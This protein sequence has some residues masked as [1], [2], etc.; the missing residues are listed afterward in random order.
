MTMLDRDAAATSRTLRTQ[1]DVEERIRAI[2]FKT[3]PPGKVGAELEWTVHHTA[4]PAEPLRLSS[5]RQALG[6]HAPHTLFANSPELPLPADGLV[7]CEP[8]GQVELS[9]A[10]APSL[11]ALHEAVSSDHAHLVR[12]LDAAGLSLGEHGID[13]HRTPRRLLRTPRYDAMEHA[14]DGR[15]PHGRI[16]MCS[17]AGLQACLDA[18]PPGQVATR[19]AAANAVGPALLAAFATADRHAG[20]DTG[21]ASARMGAWL[22]MDP[23]LTGPVTGPADDPAEG[24]VRYALAA[25]V[26]CVRG[27]DTWIAPAGLTLTGWLDGAVGRPLTEAD[28]DY[29]LSTLFPPVRPRGYLEIRYLDAQPG[30]GWFAPVAVLATLLGRP[31]VTDR[32][33]DLAAATADRWHDASRL[34]LADRELRRTA[35]ALLDLACRNLELPAPLGASLLDG[36]RERL[37]AKEL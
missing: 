17:T 25:P 13:P 21:W 32:A 36:V 6:P 28:L 29:H 15:G 23:R 22:G 4:A 24:W 37:H 20:R 33:L 35:A 1:E 5:L 11:T 18:G 31:E 9:S 10:P 27:D 34:G 12:L 16:M 8:G 2:C 14:F 26:V 19:W 7:T 3:G 30:D